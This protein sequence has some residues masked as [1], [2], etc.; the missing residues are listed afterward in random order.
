MNQPKTFEEGVDIV[1]K[2]LRELLISKQHDYGHKNITTTGIVGIIVRVND[3]IARLMNLYGFV[4]ETYKMTKGKHESVLDT[5]MD[6]ANYGIIAIMV[7]KGY[8]E[9]ELA[10]DAP[11]FEIGS[12]V[13][14]ADESIDPGHEGPYTIAGS[15]GSGRLLRNKEGIERGWFPC[16]V[17][18]SKN[19][20][21]C[22]I[23]LDGETWDERSGTHSLNKFKEDYHISVS[24]MVSRVINNQFEVVEGDVIELREGD[25]FVSHQKDSSGSSGMT[26]ETDSKAFIDKHMNDMENACDGTYT[27]TEVDVVLMNVWDEAYRRGLKK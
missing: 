26:L 4:N 25:V 24:N 5:W 22:S 6:L 2:D 10:K 14:F 12:I 27:R 11:E 3:K 18:T 16:N 20:T 9:L 21:Q 8:F 1:L 15:A 7:I 23:T 19:T 17:L 13:Y